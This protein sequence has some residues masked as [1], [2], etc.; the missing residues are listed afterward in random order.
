LPQK[1]NRLESLNVPIWHRSCSTILA[2]SR[3]GVRA[4]SKI[5]TQ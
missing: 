3:K 1:I 2:L 5:A 4:W